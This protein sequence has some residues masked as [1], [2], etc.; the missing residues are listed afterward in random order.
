[1]G[2]HPIF[3]ALSDNTWIRILVN[4]QLAYMIPWLYS[5]EYLAVETPKDIGVFSANQWLRS[6]TEI[7]SSCLSWFLFCKEA[8]RHISSLHHFRRKYHMCVS[9]T[10]GYW[11]RGP[12]PHVTAISFLRRLVYPYYIGLV[13][14][15]TYLTTVMLPSICI[16]PRHQKESCEYKQPEFIY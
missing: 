7:P 1:M 10:C 16:S 2:H 12:C 11:F 14:W 8:D 9:E 6:I 4:S 13:S 5:F 3:T 15:S